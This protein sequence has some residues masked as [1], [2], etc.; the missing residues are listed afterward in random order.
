MLET[1]NK[2]IIF[3][4]LL[5]ISSC[6]KVEILD[7]IVFDNN[8]LAKIS[9]NAEKKN[10]II[11]Y[12][13]KFIDPFIDHSLDNSPILYFNDWTANNIRTIGTSNYFEINI[14]DASVKKTE[15]PNI[16]SKKY[17]EKIWEYWLT[18]GSNENNN[19]LMT[20]GV[21]LMKSGKLDEALNLFIDLSKSD[22]NWA[23]PINKIATIRYLQGDFYGSIRDIQ[24]TLKIE[25]R[26]FGAIAGL[27]QINLALGRYNESLKNLDFAINIYPFIGI[28]NLRPILMDLIEKSEI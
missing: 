27:A 6:Q 12:E 24:S 17:E 19:T 22:P 11:L 9:I 20:K 1:K 16:D 15:I 13:P 18:S 10:T 28:K 26:H 2:I 25:P 7:P 3:I 14:I 5:F 21:K 4:I 8:Q 23:E